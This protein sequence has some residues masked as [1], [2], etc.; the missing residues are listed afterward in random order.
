METSWY[1][2]VLG[3]ASAGSPNS[4]YIACFAVAT[5]YEY[6]RIN[7]YRSFSHAKTTAA[8]GL[9]GHRE[10]LENLGSFGAFRGECRHAMVVFN[11]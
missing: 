3:F 6:L 8:I 1:E 5:G 10:A 11:F 2:S 9:E 7:L 4:P